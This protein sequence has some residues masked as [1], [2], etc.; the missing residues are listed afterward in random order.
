MGSGK[1]WKYPLEIMEEA[2]P[3]R[4][5]VSGGTLLPYRRRVN[6]CPHLLCAQR[7]DSIHLLITAPKNA[8][9]RLAHCVSHARGKYIMLYAG[10]N[11]SVIMQLHV[12][13]IGT[14]NRV[15]RTLATPAEG[16]RI[17]HCGTL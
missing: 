7:Y 16:I 13:F 6:D 9:S 2:G 1:S 15:L 12:L 17:K 5:A 8:D 10:I 4:A 11:F 3:T 14:L